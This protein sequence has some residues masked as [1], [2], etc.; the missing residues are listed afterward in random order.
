MFIM[1]KTSLLLVIRDERCCRWGSPYLDAHKEEDIF[2]DRGKALF[3]DP[4]IYNDLAKIFLN[5]RLDNAIL[6]DNVP[7]AK[8][9]HLS[10]IW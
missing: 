4:G 1:L 5:H 10:R 6:R 3:L 7:P 2:L 9:P 8:A